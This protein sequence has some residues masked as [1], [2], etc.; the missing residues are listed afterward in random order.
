MIVKLSGHSIKT[1]CNHKVSV[2]ELG[3]SKGLNPSIES[4][5][6]FNLTE[7]SNPPNPQPHRVFKIDLQCSTTLK[8]EGGGVKDEGYHF[9]KIAV[10]FDS[11]LVL[12]FAEILLKCSVHFIYSSRKC[13]LVLCNTPHTRQ[14]Y[15]VIKVRT[16]INNSYFMQTSTENHRIWIW[17]SVYS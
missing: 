14:V 11:T 3:T 7:I 4:T 8:L 10:G 6:G 9:N 5:D 17:P 1:S 2:D 15:L 12:G 16:M 13:T